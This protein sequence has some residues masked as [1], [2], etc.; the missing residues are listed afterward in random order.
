[1]RQSD[2][3]FGKTKDFPKITKL[4]PRK[5]TQVKRALIVILFLASIT[6][7]GC[8]SNDTMQG[9]PAVTPTEAVI[10]K[11]AC[12]TTGEINDNRGYWPV[13]TV[14]DDSGNPI[15]LRQDIEK[16]APES[17]NHVRIADVIVF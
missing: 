10:I 17:R 16:V 14:I 8:H 1:M 6:I 5:V 15:I 9:I 4:E 12:R 7:N 13:G 2:T 3:L 11:A